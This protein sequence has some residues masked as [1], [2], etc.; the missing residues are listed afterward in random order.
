MT[1]KDKAEALLCYCMS[2][3]K[4]RWSLADYPIRYSENVG[5][6]NLAPNAR[7]K[8]VRWSVALVNWSAMNGHGSSK[9]EAAQ[10]LAVKFDEWKKSGRALPRPGVVVPLEFSPVTDIVQYDLEAEVLFRDI[11]SM[12]FK[13]V[14]I[15]D[16]S[17][18][19][20]FD[21][22]EDGE[23]MISHIVNRFGIDREIVKKGNFVQ[24]FEA[25]RAANTGVP[26]I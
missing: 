12:D 2:F 6:V 14:F 13:D 5:F 16:E 8:P 22:T 18:I 4:T 24:I 17:S 11:F 9:E 20:D 7:F 3:I 26:Q 21:M 15:S 19:W 23:P 1:W 25:I 10:D